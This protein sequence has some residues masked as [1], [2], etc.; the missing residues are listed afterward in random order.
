M[1]TLTKE[2]IAKGL[3]ER[4]KS[5]EDVKVVRAH[6]G[7]LINVTSGEGTDQVS[8]SIHIVDSDAD[9]LGQMLDVLQE[10]HTKPINRSR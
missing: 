1:K 7:Y 5:G 4:F 10:E 2:D 3:A 9:S 8:T 6:N